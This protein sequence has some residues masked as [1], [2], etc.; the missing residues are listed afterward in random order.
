MSKELLEVIE[1]GIELE[2]KG[3]LNYLNFAH[4]SK[5][6][7]GKNVF[8]QLAKDEYEHMRI[9][10]DLKKKQLEGGTFELPKLPKRVM[11]KLEEVLVK[12]EH[13]EQT[14]KDKGNLN[15]VDALKMALDFEK[16][17]SAMYEELAKKATDEETK[18]LAQSLSKWEDSHYDLIQAEIDSITNTGFF[19]GIKGFEMSER[20]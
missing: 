6:I 12:P 18:K 20:Y 15:D 8:I 2:K 13:K 1:A 10:E 5:S 17:A 11:E 14:L 9:L 3:L 16:R 19:M 4:Q 7:T